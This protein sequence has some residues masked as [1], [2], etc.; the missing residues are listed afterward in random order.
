MRCFIYFFI[1]K[2]K[3]K[4]YC[5]N[6]GVLDGFLALI[7]TVTIRLQCYDNFFFKISLISSISCVKFKNEWQS[8]GRSQSR[9]A[10]RLAANKQ[11]VLQTDN[12]AQSFL[13]AKVKQNTKIKPKITYLTWVMAFLAVRTK[14]DNW[15]ICHRPILAV[16]IKMYLLS[17]RKKSITGFVKRKLR[18]L[19]FSVMVQR[20]FPSW[21]LSQTRFKTFYL[22][23]V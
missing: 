9:V 2:L 19:S 8:V 12:V 13:E 10:C 22:W 5:I 23:I 4:N 3:E 18:P 11:F 1:R 14:I 21:A 17:I 7:K 16:C 6:C 20:I 15:K